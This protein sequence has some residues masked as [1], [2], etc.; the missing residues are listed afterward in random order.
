MFKGYCFIEKD[1]QF[2]PAVNLV[3]AQ[4]TW[5]Y[6]NLQKRIFP[7]VRICDEDDFTVVHALDGKIVFPQE[8]VEMEKKMNEVS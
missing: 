2:C 8:W 1:G 3:N 7:E 5:N 4:E 6:V